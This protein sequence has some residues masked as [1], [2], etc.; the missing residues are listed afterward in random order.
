M[1]P[2]TSEVEERARGGWRSPVEPPVASRVPVP[3]RGPDV[4]AWSG[5]G[6]AGAPR[7]LVVDDEAGIVEAMQL[8]LRLKGYRVQTAL[9]GDEA[10]QKVKAERPHIILLDVCMPTMDGLQVLRHVR[11]LDRDVGVIMITATDDA[12]LRREALA[13]GATDFI[14]KPVDLKYLDRSMRAVLS[15]MLV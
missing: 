7:V 5:G 1:A 11:L 3:R 6:E 4:G 15:P 2:V 14:T 9:T 12:A 8:Y 10:I 13:G